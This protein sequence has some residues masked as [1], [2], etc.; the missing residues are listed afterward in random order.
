MQCGGIDS[1][2]PGFLC[3]QT[4]WSQAV[5]WG[6]LVQWTIVVQPCDACLDCTARPLSNQQS[7]PPTLERL[8][9]IIPTT[10]PSPSSALSLEQ[11]D[12]GQSQFTLCS[13]WCLQISRT[14]TSGF[15]EGWFQWDLLE[16]LSG[17]AIREHKGDGYYCTARARSCRLMGWPKT[18]GCRVSRGQYSLTGQPVEEKSVLFHWRVTLCVFVR[19][20]ATLEPRGQLMD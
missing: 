15:K 14:N 6:H 11:R 1:S 4:A 16:I 12:S 7:T 19:F 20:R 8:G 13:L 5:D 9:P 17:L 10:H 2:P 18:E 3:S